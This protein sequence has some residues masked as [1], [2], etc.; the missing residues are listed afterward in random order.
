MWNRDGFQ[1][2]FLTGKMKNENKWIAVHYGGGGEV[3][4]F[5]AP[6]NL[7]A[8]GKKVASKQIFIEPHR[9]WFESR[10]LDFG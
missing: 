10:L 1:K 3:L 5:F 7:L 6:P 4:K 2:F 8:N 9:F